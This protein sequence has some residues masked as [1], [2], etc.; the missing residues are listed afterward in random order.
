MVSQ[1]A[2]AQARAARA[3]RVRPGV[4]RLG[5]VRVLCAADGAK[6][7][8]AK[9]RQSVARCEQRVFLNCDLAPF[10]LP[11]ASAL[12]TRTQH[13]AGPSRPVGCLFYF[14]IDKRLGAE[15]TRVL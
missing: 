8:R 9:F 11:L 1:A 3:V 4:V 6:G 7:V 13:Q 12:W 15:P 5:V 2:H 14:Q 10:A